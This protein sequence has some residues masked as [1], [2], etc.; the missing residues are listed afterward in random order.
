MVIERNIYTKVYGIPHRFRKSFDSKQHYHSI[1]GAFSHFDSRILENPRVSPPH[2]DSGP[3]SSICFLGCFADQC[4]WEKMLWD[5]SLQLDWCSQEFGWNLRQGWKGYPCWSSSSLAI[6][7][8]SSLKSGLLFMSPAQHFWWHDVDADADEDRQ[9][10]W[11]E[12]YGWEQIPKQWRMMQ[13]RQ[14]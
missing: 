9:W 8:R 7:L 12:Q 1:G 4:T 14:N 10:R 11:W 2:Q 13:K 6:S 5:L 3:L